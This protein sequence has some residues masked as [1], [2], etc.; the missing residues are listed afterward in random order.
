VT[1]ASLTTTLTEAGPSKGA[2]VGLVEESLPEKSTS[3][4][5]EVLPHGDLEYIVRHASG[6]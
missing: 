2:L 4:G 6:K 1:T 3:L 5:P